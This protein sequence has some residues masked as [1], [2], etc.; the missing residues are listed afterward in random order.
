MTI[1]TTTLTI[2]VCSIIIITN[3]PKYSENMRNHRTVITLAARPAV[4]STSSM[5]LQA[6]D[7]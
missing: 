5:H 1:L 7:V 4:F 3:N 2:D 6:H